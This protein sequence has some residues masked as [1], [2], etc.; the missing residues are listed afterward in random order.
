M[1]SLNPLSERD[2]QMQETHALD[3]EELQFLRASY[4]AALARQMIAAQ[5]L[6]EIA[7]MLDPAMA[8]AAACA[9]WD[10]TISETN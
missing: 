6:R 8:D 9:F 10:A 3:A 5:R 4:E 1:T 2:G 7:D